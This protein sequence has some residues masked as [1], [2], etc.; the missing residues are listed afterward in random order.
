MTRESGSRSIRG[1]LAATIVGI[2]LCTT[3]PGQE[4]ASGPP[5]L[6]PLP[7]PEPAAPPKVTGT[8]TSNDESIKLSSTVLLAVPIDVAVD[9]QTGAT[10]RRPPRPDQI[11][12][13]LPFFPDVP[14]VPGKKTTDHQK[15]EP[16]PADAPLPRI[17]SAVEENGM[18]LFYLDAEIRRH[19][20]RA[21]GYFQRGC[22][23]AQAAEEGDEA[24]LAASVADFSRALELEPGHPHARLWRGYVADRKGDRTVAIADFTWVIEHDPWIGKALVYRG[25]VLLNQG[26]IDRAIA[27]FDRAVGQADADLAQVWIYRGCCYAAAGR[28]DRAI[29]DFSKAVDESPA[30]IWV[31]EKRAE[32][33]QA[34]GD[35]DRALSD[36]DTVIGLEPYDASAL[37]LR[38][39][40][41]TERA[42]YLTAARDANRLKQLMPTDPGPYFLRA[43]TA[44]SAAHQRDE[45][46][47]CVDRVAAQVGRIAPSATL[48]HIIHAAVACVASIGRRDALA[49]LDRCFELKPRLSYPYA[50]GAVINAYEGRLLPSLRDLALFLFTFRPENYR[51]YASIDRDRHR[52]T[53]GFVEIMPEYEAPPRADRRSA[54]IG[55]KCISSGLQQFLAGS[56]GFERF[57]A[58]TVDGRGQ[59]VQLPGGDSGIR[60][61]GPHERHHHRL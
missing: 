22:F 2:G 57:T 59:L 36:V 20:D 60:Y 40:I 41:L 50:C 51:L 13:F 17:R 46:L 43:V 30:P 14:S 25:K 24:A 32:S 61:N 8:S 54:A 45:N 48:P 10:L 23:R 18:R 38:I 47:A 9:P 39:S 19:P 55:E 31:L 33:Y 12:P 44:L 52:F 29:A 34:I 7:P 3:A 21:A 6:T 11:R 27:D 53:I 15:K 5:P 35:L 58:L 56:L 37:F 26:E 49:D 42:Q 28:H 4:A 16:G 1:L